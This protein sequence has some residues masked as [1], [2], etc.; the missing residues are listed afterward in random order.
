[1]IPRPC[2]QVRIARAH[3]EYERNGVLRSR[4]G[5]VRRSASA[6]KVEM[7]QPLSNGTLVRRGEFPL[8]GGLTG[9]PRKVVARAG[10]VK[11]VL[12]HVTRRV[13]RDT[14]RNF[15]VSVNSC[16]RALGYVGYLFVD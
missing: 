14:H 2:L 7:H 8:S 9:N 12:D 15:H 5:S 13:D 1:M 16:K 3:H 10:V 6:R 11:A 4:A